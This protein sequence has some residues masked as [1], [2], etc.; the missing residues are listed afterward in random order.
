MLESWMKVVNA[1]RNAY[2]H[3]ERIWNR[4]MPVIPQLLG[5]LRNAWI[6]DKPKMTNRFYA[7]FYLLLYLLAQCN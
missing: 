1:L 2:A 4:K 7:V 5:T 6:A 3:H